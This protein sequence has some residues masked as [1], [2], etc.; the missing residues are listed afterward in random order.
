[1]PLDCHASM[2]ISSSHDLWLAMTVRSTLIMIAVLLE[3]LMTYDS[4]K[5]SHNDSSIIGGIDDL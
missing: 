1:M 5:Y 3:G 4:A 2:I